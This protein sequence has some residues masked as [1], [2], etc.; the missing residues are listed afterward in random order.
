[1]VPGHLEKQLYGEAEL[2]SHLGGKT[3]G[4]VGKLRTPVSGSCFPWGELQ[5]EAEWGVG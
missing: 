5:E 4:D 3:L 2:E 1:M